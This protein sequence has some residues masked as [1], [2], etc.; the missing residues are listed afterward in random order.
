MM[1]H[2]DSMPDNW[3]EPIKELGKQSERMKSVL[4]DLLV[5]FQLESE[6]NQID[7]EIIDIELIVNSSKNAAMKRSN[8]PKSFKVDFPR[9]AL[10]KGDEFRIQSVI[11]NI[12]ENALR[13]SDQKGEIEVSMGV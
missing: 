2:D 10:I 1:L 6:A 8:P 3:K 13:Y 4:S 5:L 9:P 12:V 7:E 11:N